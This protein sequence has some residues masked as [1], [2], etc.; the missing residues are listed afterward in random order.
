MDAGTLVWLRGFGGVKVDGKLVWPARVCSADAGGEKVQKAKKS[1]KTLVHSFGDEQ[2]VWAKP[3]SLTA[4]SGRAF[5][6]ALKHASERV[7]PALEAALATTKPKKQ[8]TEA[9]PSPRTPTTTP[10]SKMRVPL[11][12]KPVP[13]PEDDS[14]SPY[15]RQRLANMAANEA[16]LAALGISSAVDAMRRAATPQAK[17]IDPEVRA[18]RALERQQQ[19]IDAQANRRT[20]SRLADTGDAERAPKRFAEEF[21]AEDEALEEALYRQSKKRAKTAG[22][23]RGGKQREGA[24]VLS[25][26][27]RASVA[28]AYEEAE[29]WL[30]EMNKF[31]SSKLSDANL[32]NVM[33]QATALATGEGVPHTFTKAWFRKGEPV[34][35]DEDLGELR[36]AA[37]RFLRPEDDPGHGWRLDH[38]IGK[39]GLFQA[40]LHTKG[41]GK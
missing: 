6:N 15:E 10:A 22:S 28:A 25:P 37:N 26:E 29:G 39:M 41:K 1:S 30:Q 32:R 16:A 2:Y 8:K 23:G 9:P 11:P 7:R 21:N 27:E 5:E 12:K 17:A 20:S 34:T 24:A 40:Y 35:L 14:L 3:E 13:S 36:A 31:F 19:L 38:P 18:A 4:S 33:K